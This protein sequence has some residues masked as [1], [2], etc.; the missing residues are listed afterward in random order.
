[1]AATGTGWPDEFVARYVAA[2]VWGDRTLGGLPRE[3]ARRAPRDPALVSGAER[4]DY[5]DL[6]RRVD[7]MAAGLLRRGIGA[8]D[9]VVL[10]L[11]NVP[12]FVVVLFALA[13]IGALPV[14][15]LP[16]HRRAE[17]SH[18]AA[19]SG[20]VAYVVPDRHEGFDYRSLATEVRADVPHLREVLVVGDPGEHGALD[21]V[22]VPGAGPVP[23]AARSEDVALLLMSGGT[24]GRPKLIPR[25]HRDYVYNAEATAEVCGLTSAD[26]TLSVLPI[27]HNLPL[28][29]PGV[30][31]TMAVGGTVVL[32]RA[33]SPETAFELIEREGVTFAAVVP[34]L[35]RLWV[36]AA[37][38]GGAPRGLRSLMVG[39][40]RCDRALAAS[41]GP[42]LGCRLIQS[43]GMAEGLLTH[44]RPEDG[45]ELVVGTQGRPLSPLDEIRVLGPDGTPVPAGEVGELWTRGPYTIRGYH[46]AP[47]YNAL[48]FDAEGFYRTGDLVRVLPSGHLVVEGRVKEVVNRGGENVSETELEEQLLEHPDVVRAAVFG[49]P[50]PDLGEIVCAALVLAGGVGKPPRAK[51]VAAFLRTRGLARFKHPD[52]LFIVDDLPLTAVGKVDKKALARTVTPT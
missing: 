38:A 28:A 11:P 26:V 42:A 37:T 5:S 33:G 51:D 48:A 50:D 16:A 23:D 47:E 32:A 8:G 1:M 49:L 14:L 4:I 24:T 52:R 15:V 34:P 41:I 36:E 17:V 10:H 39:G 22:P 27:G 3:W 9:A 25:T 40:A 2:G 12:E 21:E 30:I 20:A 18:V 43:F 19:V 46:R 44:T 31:G 45:D 29:C 13:R 7:E 35:A 6:D